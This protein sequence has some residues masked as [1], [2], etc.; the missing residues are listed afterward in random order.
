MQRILI[1]L[2]FQTNLY[3]TIISLLALGG[4]CIAGYFYAKKQFQQSSLAYFVLFL[5][6]FGLSTLILARG[7]IKEISLDDYYYLARVAYHHPEVRLKLSRYINLHRHRLNGIDY[8][9][10]R[11]HLDKDL[12]KGTLDDVEKSG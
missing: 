1:Y 5:V 6:I 7:A 3:L 4:I 2:S 12:D 8:A 9:V 10:I 11:Y